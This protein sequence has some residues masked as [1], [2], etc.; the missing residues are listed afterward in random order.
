MRVFAGRVAEYVASISLKY[1]SADCPNAWQT[2]SAGEIEQ[3]LSGRFHWHNT[4]LLVLEVTTICG[5]SGYVEINQPDQLIVGGPSESYYKGNSAEDLAMA[6]EIMEVTRFAAE[7]F[8]DGFGAFGAGSS[9]IEQAKELRA[10][11]RQPNLTSVINGEAFALS[12]VKQCTELRE[13]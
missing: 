8:G 13:L 5:F 7:G 12:L 3:F 10:L 4:Q 1:L 11:G 9:A 2:V 6:I